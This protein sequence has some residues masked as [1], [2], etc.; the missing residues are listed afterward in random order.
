MEKQLR[1]VFTIPPAVYHEDLSIDYDAV[2]RCVQFC[3]DC[4]VQGLVVPVYATE[5]FVLSNEERKKILEVCIKAANGKIPV[6]AG[7]SAAYVGEAVDLSKHACAAGADAVIAAPPHVVKVNQS[8]LF[9]YYKMINAAVNVPIFIQNLFP[10]LGTPM[11]E[12]FLIRLLTE[13]ENVQY[14]KEETGQSKYLITTLH[15]YEIEHPG[16]KLKGIMGGNGSRALIEEYDRGICGTMP[17]CQF[18]DLVVGIWNLLE[19][20]KME[21]AYRMH[22]LCLPAFLFSGAYGV[23][24]YKHILKKRG[25][26]DFAGS[27]PAGWPVMDEAAWRELDR[28]FSL[29]EPMLL[30]K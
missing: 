23:G 14:I 29:V 1:G 8:E 5:Y 15:N 7:V 19:Q 11:N 13:L 2:S 25:V 3:L 10:P 16:G 9:D 18:A 22:A 6:V 27:R 12:A 20:G 4:G 21:E 28:V 17:S 26:I 30:L 24:C